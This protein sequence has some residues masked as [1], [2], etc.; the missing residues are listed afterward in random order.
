MCGRFTIT[1]SYDELKDYVHD[2]FG[3]GSIKEDLYAPNY[4]VAPGT[5]IIS[6]IFD[7]KKHRIGLL[8][9]G[10]SP[11]FKTEQ[12]MNLINARSETLFE[13]PLFKTAAL[14]QRCVIIADGFYEWKQDSSKQPMRIT[15]NDQMFLMAG[16]W[17]QA[18]NDKQEKEFNVAIITTKS[19]AQ[20]NEI[21]ERMPVILKPEDVKIWLDNEI[22]DINLLKSVLIPYEEALTIYPVSKKVNQATYKESDAILKI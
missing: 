8:K 14:N 9:W 3:I 13:K 15:T 4:N 19:N 1:V 17:N 20:M 18:V 12:K 21:H 22:K 7:G 10:F 5:K 2:T 16:V 6:V 11:S